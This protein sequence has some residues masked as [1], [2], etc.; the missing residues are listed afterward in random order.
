MPTT[1][2]FHFTLAS[3]LAVLL[4]A[5]CVHSPP[6]DPWDP[7][8]PVNRFNYKLNEKADQYAV[9]PA[10]QVYNKIVP[11]PVQAS[12]THFFDNASQ[13]VT[14]VNSLLQLKWGK[15]NQSLGRFMINSSFGLGGLFDVA[16]KLKVP[17]PDE[18]F[19]QTLGYWGLGPGMYIYLPLLGPSDGRDLFGKLGDQFTNPINYVDQIDTINNDYPWVPYALRG[20]E[21]LNLRASLLGFDSTLKQQFDPYAFVR[22]YYLENRREAVYDGHVP[23]KLK[24]S[25]DG[26]QDFPS[27]APDQGSSD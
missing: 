20:I 7:L 4:L 13:P 24:R 8:E 14:M 2:R 19:G 6:S 11:A 17:H 3:L 12:V 9:R 1:S 26:S 21:G 27:A 23:A 5:G 16:S 10:A 22:S 15:F 18:D 25:D